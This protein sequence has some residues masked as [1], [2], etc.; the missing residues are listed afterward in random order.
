MLLV[1]LLLQW[2]PTP[3]RDAMLAR[4]SDRHTWSVVRTELEPK[5]QLA[6]FHPE[7]RPVSISLMH[8]SS[9]QSESDWR[10]VLEACSQPA[11]GLVT[12]QSFDDVMPSGELITK[13]APAVSSQTSDSLVT[14]AIELASLAD[15][16]VILPYLL[17]DLSHT[18]TAS[19]A[20]IAVS[21]PPTDGPTSGPGGGPGGGI[22]APLPEPAAAIPV[23]G[24]VIPLILR[25]RRRLQNPAN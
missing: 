8:G 7:A 13:S 18:I 17:G 16:P 6:N 11:R 9:S 19:S 4:Y 5:W 12:L 21:P 2:L 22:G 24:M 23:I 10:S 1:F 3:T 15:R 20:D 14:P 25:R